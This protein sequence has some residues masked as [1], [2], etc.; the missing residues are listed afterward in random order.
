MYSLRQMARVYRPSGIDTGLTDILAMHLLRLEGTPGILGAGLGMR[1]RRGSLHA[2]EDPCLVV[3]VR[4][5][6]PRAA[7]TRSQVLPRHLD[8]VPVDVVPLA[9]RRHAGPV[10]PE[11][12]PVT[13]CP[14]MGIMRDRLG[15][16]TAGGIVLE[17]KGMPCLL[18]AGHVLY[19][20]ESFKRGIPVRPASTNQPS[21]SAPIIGRT[22]DVHFGLDAGL[23]RLEGSEG[24]NRAVCEGVTLRSP[25]A[26]VIGA[27][28]E[29]CGARSGRT[30]A[31]VASIG[32]VGRLFP[33]MVLQPVLPDLDPD[34]LS[35]PGDSGALWYDPVDSRAVGLHVQGGAR[36]AK[37]AE[38]G[39]ATPLSD[40]LKAFAC[41]WD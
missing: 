31:V 34:P 10:A 3:Y 37:S 40:V 28:L 7:L 18:T 38:F 39:V 9:P 1:T 14:G 12:P 32:K 5:K 41:S 15:L 2:V 27:T 29:K 22:H 8:G 36:T 16:G 24:R 35:Q 19:G 26:A 11:P 30:Q 20:S 6:R 17:A 13:V 4:R 33:A 21:G 23:V 25:K